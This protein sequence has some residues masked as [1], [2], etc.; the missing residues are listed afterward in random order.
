MPADPAAGGG[1]SEGPSPEKLIWKA[2]NAAKEKKEE[3]KKRG[4]CPIAK[5]D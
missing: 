3:N 4:F 2:K 5:D 1:G